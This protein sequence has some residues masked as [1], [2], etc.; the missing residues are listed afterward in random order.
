MHNNDKSL[1]LTVNNDYNDVD[2]KQQKSGGSQSALVTLSGTYG[3]DLDLT[4]GT[5][6]TTGPGTYSLSQNC[7]TV[8]G[9]SISVTQD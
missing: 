8:G 6:N 3:T 5:N 7:Q 4:M 1:M 9:C 2:I